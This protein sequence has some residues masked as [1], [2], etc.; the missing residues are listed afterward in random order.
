MSPWHEDKEETRQIG[1]CFHLNLNCQPIAENGQLKS[2][3]VQFAHD[4]ES[5]Q[6]AKNGPGLARR[7]CV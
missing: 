5:L 4:H 7:T 1:S 2:I 3:L 6:D